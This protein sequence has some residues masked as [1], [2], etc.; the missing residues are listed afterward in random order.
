MD[1][2]RLLVAAEAAVAADDGLADV[3]GGVAGEGGVAAVVVVVGHAVDGVV[4]AV[5]D[6]GAEY[7]CVATRLCSGI[8]LSWLQ[9]LL[10]W[11]KRDF[12]AMYQWIWLD[13]RHLH[14]N[15]LDLFAGVKN[16]GDEDY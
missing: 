8:L 1:S 6:Y 16:A 11:W 2:I 13:G 3:E 12:V 9:L 4:A 5:V 15:S 14:H 7:D 10:L